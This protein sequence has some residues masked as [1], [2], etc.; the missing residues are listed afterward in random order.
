MLPG[1]LRCPLIPASWTG[2]PYK[3]S[4]RL[5][6][7][8][9]VHHAPLMPPCPPQAFLNRLCGAGTP[10]HPPRTAPMPYPLSEGAFHPTNTRIR[11]SVTVLPFRPGAHQFLPPL[12]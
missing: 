12:S 4:S 9:T 10:P 2:I 6:P 8:Q 11:A 7:R 3:R 5:F 1:W